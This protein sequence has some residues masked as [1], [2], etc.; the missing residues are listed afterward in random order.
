MFIDLLRLRLF[1][2]LSL[3]SAVISTHIF[4]QLNQVAPGNKV[5][6]FSF[7]MNPLVTGLLLCIGALIMNNQDQDPDTGAPAPHEDNSN[8]T[9][10]IK[11]NP[12]ITGILMLIAVPVMILRESARSLYRRVYEDNAGNTF[13]GWILALLTGVGY[14]YSQV[15]GQAPLYIWLPFSFLLAAVTFGYAYPVA[16]LAAF[17][18]LVRSSRYLWRRVHD[19]QNSWLTDTLHG[20]ANMMSFATGILL[21][22]S[23]P[24]ADNTSALGSAVLGLIVAFATT[25]FLVA[26]FSW[27]RLALIATVSGL[28]IGKLLAAP[29]AAFLPAGLAYASLISIAAVTATWVLFVFPVAHALIDHNLAPIARLFQKNYDR[30]YRQ[31][32]R[33]A[34][35]LPLDH[36]TKTPPREQEDRTFSLPLAHLVNIVGAFST[37]GLAHALLI[38][39]KFGYNPWL[40]GL[41]CLAAAFGSYLWLGF[42]ANERTN[43]FSAS[44]STVHIL[45]WLLVTGTTRLILTSFTNLVTVLLGCYIFYTIIYPGF[46]RLCLVLGANLLRSNFAKGL[47]VAHEN[48]WEEF[49]SLWWRLLQAP[50]EAYGDKTRFASFL[51]HLATYLVT[52]LSFSFVANFVAGYISAAPLVYISASIGALFTYLLAGK[53]ILSLGNPAVGLTSAIPGTTWLL[54]SGIIP[55]ARLAEAYPLAIL[56]CAVA[57]VLLVFP[58]TYVLARYPLN[59][60]VVPFLLPRMDVLHSWSWRQFSSLWDNFRE[61]YRTVRD[62]LKPIWASMVNSWYEAKRQLKE[63]WEKLTGNRQ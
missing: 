19:N 4:Y 50:A 60:L 40:H 5:A 36:V 7:F 53:L 11:N 13:V 15:L 23:L 37:A 63:I 30:A 35:S 47:I 1:H 3:S 43:K 29:L 59:V 42:H 26:L 48:A 46:Y 12:I 2:F 52:W 25:T 24:V 22:F 27:R 33:H 41:I 57:W 17:R 14:A 49:L 32:E 38:W 20:A 56:L 44:L 54:S 28:G 21:G 31:E 16:Y 51:P 6:D 55:A 45:T 62:M 10:P 39:A 8:K 34:L 58:V 9:P 18:P 61:A